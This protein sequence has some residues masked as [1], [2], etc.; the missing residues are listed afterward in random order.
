MRRGRSY[1]DERIP[2]RDFYTYTPDD[3]N[4]FGSCYNHHHSERQFP[5]PHVLFPH[6]FPPPEPFRNYRSHEQEN[7]YSRFGRYPD[8]ERIHVRQRNYQRP[9]VTTP[10]Q[11]NLRPAPVVTSVEKKPKTLAKVIKSKKRAGTKR[12]KKKK[13]KLQTGKEKKISRVVIH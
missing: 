11:I 12:H 8:V 6:N 13:K 5:D 10:K 7:F 9:I 1:F 4:S 2:S 3:P